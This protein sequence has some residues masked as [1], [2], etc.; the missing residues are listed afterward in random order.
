MFFHA[1]NSLT[2]YQQNK[3][4]NLTPGGVLYNKHIR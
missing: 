3:I 4:Q 1:K 2:T